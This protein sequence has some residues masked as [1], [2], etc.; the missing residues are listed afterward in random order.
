MVVLIDIFLAHR[1]CGNIAG[2]VTQMGLEVI[3]V[4]D[5]EENEGFVVLG[6][7]GPMLRI[8]VSMNF[9]TSKVY[10]EYSPYQILPW[11]LRVFTLD[12]EVILVMIQYSP[13]QT[14]QLTEKSGYPAGSGQDNRLLMNISPTIL[15][16]T[17]IDNP[18]HDQ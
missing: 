13:N 12:V 15:V 3:C 17:V 16:V 5:F 4:S 18:S 10:S 11:M 9:P 14:T 6:Q 8:D 2:I 1:A 7:T